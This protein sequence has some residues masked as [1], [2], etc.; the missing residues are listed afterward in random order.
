MQNLQA[1]NEL[2]LAGQAPHEEKLKWNPDFG[3]DI[4]M[5]ITADGRWFYQGGEIKR[6]AMR[7]L[8]ASILRKEQ[9][10]FYLV[11]PVE[12]LGIQVEDAP[13]I[14]QSLEILGKG[15]EQQIKVTTNV[16]ECFWLDEQHP[17][18][19]TLNSVT[20]QPRPYALVRQQLETLIARTHYY[21]LVEYSCMHLVDKEECYGVWSCGQFFKL[22]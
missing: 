2:A 3:G 20:N 1:L 11:T 13:F 17:L 5:Q 12:K 14:T 10:Q 6:H 15:T 9:D 18:C 21:E 19:L 16:D 8:F 22:A 7:C 4:D